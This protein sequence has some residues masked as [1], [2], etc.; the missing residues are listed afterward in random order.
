MPFRCDVRV[1]ARMSKAAAAALAMSAR[2]GRRV[3]VIGGPPFRRCRGDPAL[4]GAKPI[5]DVRT[6]SRQRLGP[7]RRPEAGFAADGPPM[8]LDDQQGPALRAGL[9]HRV[10]MDAETAGDAGE[11]VPLMHPGDAATRPLRL[12]PIGTRLF[13]Q[14]MEQPKKRWIREGS[15]G[16]RRLLWSGGIGIGAGFPR[17]VVVRKDRLHEPRRRPCPSHFAGS[18]ARRPAWSE[19]ANA[20]RL[21]PM[22]GLSLGFAGHGSP[23]CAHMGARFQKA[24]VIS[25]Q[26]R[27]GTPSR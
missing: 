24:G 11:T 10:L 22:N 17:R 12:P 3:A 16:A 19:P 13:E 2:A 26:G 5:D 4:L 25:L 21:A 20:C 1:A 9:R 15:H 7:L 18:G 8:L 23:A 27:K 14:R 6:L